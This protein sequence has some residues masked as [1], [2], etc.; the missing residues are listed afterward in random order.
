MTQKLLYDERVVSRRL[1]HQSGI[2]VAERMGRNL[3]AQFV[4]L[5]NARTFE[6]RLEIPMAAGVSPENMRPLIGFHLG[7]QRFRKILGNRNN[8]RPDR[9]SRLRFG[10]PDCNKPA[11]QVNFA[12][13]QRYVRGLLGRHHLCLPGSSCQHQRV[14]CSVPRRA[15]LEKTAKFVLRESPLWCY[16][17]S[18]WQRTADLKAA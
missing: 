1:G 7:A 16:T 10:R 15:G 17:S 5:R 12:L 3:A 13:K 2:R 4:F 8:A 18:P 14:E 11:L 9:C 6:D